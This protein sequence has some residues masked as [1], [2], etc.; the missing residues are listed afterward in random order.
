[1][2]YMWVICS[3]PVA[4]VNAKGH[5]V[6]PIFAATSHEIR[7][8]FLESFNHKTLSG[9]E[10]IEAVVLNFDFAPL[11]AVLEHPAI[12]AQ[13]TPSALMIY[14]NFQSPTDS[15]SAG[16]GLDA[17]L[18]WWRTNMPG[19]A[20]GDCYKVDAR[21]DRNQLEAMMS[22]AEIADEQEWNRVFPIDGP[23]ETSTSITASCQ[24]FRALA[25][26]LGVRRFWALATAYGNEAVAILAVM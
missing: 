6:Q 1:M 5:I 3:H 2:I 20:P 11:C 23:S 4:R 15:H 21:S 8:E 26:A 9:A 13:A 17:W 7:E 10:T 22:L 18:A 16:E 12:K 19:N 24:I 25:D 14:L